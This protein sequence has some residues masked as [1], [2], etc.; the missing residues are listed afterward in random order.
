[1]YWQ[2]FSQ[3]HL[4]TLFWGLG[5]CALRGCGS[6]FCQNGVNAFGRY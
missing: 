5:G 3:T 4:V 2:Y 6:I 1:M